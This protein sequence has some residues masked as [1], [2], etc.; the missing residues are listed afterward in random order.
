MKKK[1]EDILQSVINDFSDEM[2]NEF[3]KGIED[4]ICNLHSPKQILAIVE[5]C[6]QE[7]DKKNVFL[8][9]INST[10]E[11]LGH[12]CILNDC[13]NN[14]SDSSKM[15][16]DIV[17]AHIQKGTINIFDVGLDFFALG[18]IIGK[19]EERQRKQE[20]RNGVLN[21]NI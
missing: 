18:I 6:K 11:L 8:Y 9:S 21:G 13:S 20:K 1:L 16:D 7:R 19:R 2:F 17:Q 3:I 15:F 14:G 5:F 4:N 12:Q 10:M